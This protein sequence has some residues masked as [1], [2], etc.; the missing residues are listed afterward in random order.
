MHALSNERRNLT[1]SLR[2]RM[3]PQEARLW[4]ELRLLKPQGLHFRR[5]V[6][7]GPYIVDFA[8]TSRRLAVEIDGG[9]HAEDGHGAR[10]RERDAWLRSIGFEILRFWN[11]DINTGLAAAVDH[12]ALTALGR[13]PPPHEGEG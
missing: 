5:Q 2:K 12:I 3:T 7:L 1:R 9:Q 6:P 11:S 10:D 4:A 13:V 8:C